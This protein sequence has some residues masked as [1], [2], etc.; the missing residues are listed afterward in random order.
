MK[1]LLIKYLKISTGEIAQKAKA[2]V[3]KPK[4]LSSISLISMV[5]GEKQLLQ[6]VL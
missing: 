1:H 3:S 6:I 4:D 2:C 5:E